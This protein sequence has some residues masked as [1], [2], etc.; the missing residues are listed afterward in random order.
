M[1]PRRFSECLGRLGW[2]R[3][4]LAGLLSVGATTPEHW[5]S[6]RS[7]VDARVADW[8]ERLVAARA[9]VPD[10]PDGWERGRSRRGAEAGADGPLDPLGDDWP[11]AVR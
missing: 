7:R 9:T 4:Q 6:G 3:R 1:T 8:L 2:S 10:L 5:A 11:A